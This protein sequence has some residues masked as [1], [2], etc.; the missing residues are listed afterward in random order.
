MS[1]DACLVVTPYSN[2]PRP[3]GILAHYQALDE[4]GLPFILYDIPSRTSMELGV[5]LIMKLCESCHSIVGL[6]ASNGNL[7]EITEII[8]RSTQ[9]GWPFSVFSG[10]D[11]LTLPTL[12]VEGVG[13]ISV[14]VRGCISNSGKTDDIN[15]IN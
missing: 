6:K 3:K 13:V 15:P 4:V 8:Y 5:E 12:A 11:S 9:F 1:A 14:A 10:D 7:D 2:R